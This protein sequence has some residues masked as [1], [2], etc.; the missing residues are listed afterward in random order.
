[1]EN[2]KFRKMLETHY[3][4]NAQGWQHMMMARGLSQHDAEDVVQ[5]AYTRMLQYADA[6]EGGEE[7]FPDWAFTILQNCAKDAYQEQVRHGMVCD[8][9]EEV[10]ALPVEEGRLT[11]AAIKQ[12]LKSLPAG[13]KKTIGRLFFLSK[14]GYKDIYKIVED[15]PATVRKTVQRLRD[16]LKEKF[17]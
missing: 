11:L 16:E 9:Q 1:M 2:N 8:G 13:N 4:K 3:R 17:A 12:Y 7:K 5:E 14:L 10:L 15:S 6:F